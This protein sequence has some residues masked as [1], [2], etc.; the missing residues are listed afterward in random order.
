MGGDDNRPSKRKDLTPD[1]KQDKEKVF[2]PPVQ[3]DSV[4]NHP[5]I[6]SL[7]A[8]PSLNIAKK[9]KMAGISEAMSNIDVDTVYKLVIDLSTRV[10]SLE[11]QLSN[12]DEEIFSLRR[13]HANLEKQLSDLRT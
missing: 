5:S 11:T 3:Y 8:S 12:K 10:T 1:A 6:L 7:Q 4:N 13:D 9:C 2:K